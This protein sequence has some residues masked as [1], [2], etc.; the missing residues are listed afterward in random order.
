MENE[1]MEKYKGFN[2]ELTKEDLNKEELEC[3][4]KLMDGI[5][6]ASMEEKDEVAHLMDVA[7]E[8]EE[9]VYT[10]CVRCGKKF[11]DDD[12]DPDEKDARTYCKNCLKKM[13][14]PRALPEGV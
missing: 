13:W 3:Y 12:E 11:T 10:H 6:K 14:S 8:A 4:D 9:T 2:K 5:G 1:N 7:I